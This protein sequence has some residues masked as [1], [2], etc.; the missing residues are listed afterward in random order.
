MSRLFL[1]IFSSVSVE[2]F[3]N[4]RRLHR[5]ITLRHFIGFQCSLVQEQ[6]TLS[7]TYCSERIYDLFLSFLHNFGFLHV[8]DYTTSIGL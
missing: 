1:E 3:Q 6:N 4:V 7:P 5:M 8:A 2:D